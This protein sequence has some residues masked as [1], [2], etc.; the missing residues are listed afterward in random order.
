MLR[1][2]DI[3]TRDV[4]TVRPESTVR[5]AMELLATRHVS[6]APVV[7]GDKVVGVISSSDLLSFAAHGAATPIEHQRG[8]NGALDSDGWDG[9]SAPGPFFQRIWLRGEDG[10][11][12]EGRVTTPPAVDF[13][14]KTVSHVMTRRVRSMPP[15]T[16]VSWAADCMRCERIHRVLV[17]ENDRLL[18][19]VSVS[20]IARA[21]A[22]HRL[23][24]RR[25]V[26]PRPALPIAA[27]T[28]RR[29]M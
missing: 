4:L 29:R 20:D 19:I 2:R 6:G 24:A 21:V 12:S 17:M 10:L 25:Y 9:S 28:D 26:F 13:D 5:E 1:L 23:T 22:E 11:L 8:A 7:S 18:G 27:A 15:D 3:M 16:A 14:A